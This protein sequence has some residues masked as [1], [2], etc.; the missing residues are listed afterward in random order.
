MTLVVLV[1]AAVLAGVAA[2]GVLWPFGR[3]RHLTLERLAD[4][5][6][7][8]RVSLLRSLRELDAERAAGALAEEDYLE[9]RGETR[10]RAVAVLRALEA[11]EGTG[12]L[13]VGLRELRSPGASNGQAA[14]R[15]G[16]RSVR[17]LP[18]LV[19]GL[20][21]VGVIVPLLISAMG[22]RTSGDPFTGGV[23]M[24][25][26]PGDPTS[27]PFREQRVQD[28][29]QDIAARLDLAQAYQESG[30]VDA[31]VGQYLAAL[32][33]DPDSA[34]AHAQLGFLVYQAGRPEEGLVE[35]ERALAV[36]PDYPE[37]LYFKGVILLNG[38]R[39]PAE[40]AEPFRAY[41][42]NSPFGARRAEVEDLLERAAEATA[43]P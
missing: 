11:R 41:L 28:H 20:V 15:A 25:D 7:D 16:R 23:Q 27:V 12:E 19:A 21:L 34:E 33:I 17:A 22:D 6:E 4:P 43:E 32:A 36:E 10:A 5:L 2:A 13:A 42:E 9:L 1:A 3:N 38:L 8:E 37:A 30:N 31:A 24:P 29:P 18:A 14:R 40:A 26:P 35:V 39:R